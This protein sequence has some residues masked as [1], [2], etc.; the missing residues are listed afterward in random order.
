MSNWELFTWISVFILGIGSII[1]FFLFLKDIRGIL[2][3]FIKEKN[4]L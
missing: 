1:I 2:S 4:E 3:K